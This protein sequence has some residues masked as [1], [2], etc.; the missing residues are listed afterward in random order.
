MK[1]PPIKQAIAMALKYDDNYQSAITNL[2]ASQRAVESARE[3]MRVGLDLTYTHTLATAEKERHT[4]NVGLTLTVP[5]DTHSEQRSLIA[6][7][8]SYEEAKVNL[9]ETKAQLVKKIKQSLLGI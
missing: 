1:Q 7:R 2:R 5:I 3:Q 4:N 8:I 9:R 6:A